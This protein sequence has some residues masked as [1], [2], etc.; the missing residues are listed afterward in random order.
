MNNN[1]EKLDQVGREFYSSEGS[2]SYQPNGNIR[3]QLCYR[4]DTGKRRRKSFIAITLDECY[5]RANKY[6]AEC[7]GLITNSDST[8]PDILRAKSKSDL[9]MNYIKRQTHNGNERAARSIENHIIGQLPVCQITIEIIEDYMEYITKYADGTID[10]IFRDIT[11][12]FE[13]AKQE[14]LIRKNPMKSYD[15]RKPK[16]E[17]VARKASALTEN[18]QKKLVVE[19][20][21]RKIP[22]GALDYTNQF[23]I[24]L[25]SGLRMGEVNAL[26][27]EDIDMNN[28]IL[29]VRNTVI[30]VDGKTELGNTTKTYAG[31][32]DVPISGKLGA[33]L[34]DALSKAKKN[35]HN[36]IFF[37]YRKGGIISTDQA[38]ACFKT[39]CK[40]CNIEPRGSHILRHTFATR[41]IEAGVP[42]I[43]LAK[44]LGHTDIHVTLDTY[45]DVFDRMNNDA[46]DKLDIHL[47]AL[48]NE[49][50]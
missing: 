25:Y 45:A 40:R 50:I 13:I 11:N 31:S 47:D 38:S 18:E 33:V 15:M 1:Y 8:I 23:L 9:S 34:T 42:A 7:K 14:G 32:R 19:L 6:A 35:P 46:I 20:K 21:E 43:V 30:K 16:S 27:A 4:D 22:Y 36:L 41:C 44:W 48:N 3:L 17:K 29:H 10:K 2:I 37:D 39:Y 26:T 12:A 49:D 5:K 24:Q 28:N